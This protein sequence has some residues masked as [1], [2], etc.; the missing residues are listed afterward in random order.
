MPLPK[1]K[2]EG[3]VGPIIADREHLST[4]FLGRFLI[5]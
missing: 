5:F 4:C 3:V 1:A 2:P